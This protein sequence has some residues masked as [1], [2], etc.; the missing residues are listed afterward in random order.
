MDY[1][2]VK[3]A[4]MGSNSGYGGFHAGCTFYDNMLS[5]MGP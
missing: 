1:R 4:L 5:L 3:E 2:H